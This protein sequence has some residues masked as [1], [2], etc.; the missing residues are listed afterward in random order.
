MSSHHYIECGLMNVF[1]EGLDPI[2]DDAGDDIVTIPL[3]N[4]L[5][6]A[7]ALGIVSHEHG[8][9]GA[10]LRFL[11]TEMGYTQAE[12][13]S[14]VHHEKQAIGRW[15]RGEGEINSSAELIIRLLSIEK[16]SLGLEADVDT[17]SRQSVPSLHSQPIKI[18]KVSNDSG[19]G[20]ELIAA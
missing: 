10:E 11:R 1:V 2:T 12:L 14:L 3:V 9:S 18:Q 17:L 6:K 7:I 15:E 5:H 16:L 8:I 20:Y 19:G 13:A 4:Q